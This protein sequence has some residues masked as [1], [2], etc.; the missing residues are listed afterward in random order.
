MPARRGRP[1]AERANSI[2]QLVLEAARRLFLDEGFDAV[3]MERVVAIAGVSKGTLYARYAS[4]EALFAAVIKATVERWSDIASQNNH[5][6]TDDIEQ[7]LRHHART[8]A[9]AL[10]WPDV[11]AFQRLIF[12][13]QDRFPALSQAMHETGAKYTVHYIVRDIEAA[14]L[15][16]GLPVK[17]AI[18]V[19]RMLVESLT[20]FQ[21]VEGGDKSAPGVDITQFGQR[22]VDLLIAARSSW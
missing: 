20:G 10:Q 22:V 13:V 14:A 16:D 3:T 1:S 8:I 19:A 12:S 9:G 5:L 21:L 18:S 17:D 11:V 15:R 4:K 6:F 2:D 7:R